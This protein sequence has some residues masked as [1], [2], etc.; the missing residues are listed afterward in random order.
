MKREQFTIQTVSVI[1][2][3]KLGTPLVAC[4]ASKGFSVIGVDANPEVVRLM[5][6]GV[7][8]V[9]EPGLDELLR[10]GHN[11][12]LATLDCRHAVLNSDLSFIVVPTPSEPSGG[13]STQHVLSVAEMIGEALRE[14][15]GYH[16]IALVSTVLPGTTEVDIKAVL[17]G[18]SGKKCGLDFGLCYSPEFI[19]LGRVIRDM[20][21]PDFILIGESDP[22]SGETLASFYRAFCDNDPAIS[23][24]NIL[25]AELTKIS[26]NSYITMKISFANNLAEICERLPGTDVDVVTSAMGQDTRIGRKYLKGALGYGGPCFPRDNAAFAYMARQVGAQPTMAE[27]TDSVNSR[28]IQRLLEIVTSHLDRSRTRVGILGLAYKP[29]TAVIEGSQSVELAQMLA[30]QGVPTVVYD[31]VAMD[32]ARKVLGQRALYARSMEECIQE[33]DVILLATPWAE[34]CEIR[35]EFFVSNS[36]RRVLIDC[37][38]LLCPADF[39]DVVEYVTIGMEMARPQRSPAYVKGGNDDQPPSLA[40]HV[41]GAHRQASGRKG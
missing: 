22:H 32:H 1:G 21:N 41:V 37:W 30:N 36:H 5:E 26:L 34:F 25:N 7:A 10:S 24:M 39:R 35:P 27:A 13:F 14:K 29:D 15:P 33:A 38:R 23:R 20:L 19:A 3:G 4:C 12:I 8:S 16:L 6:A 40:G 2:L 28:Q 17:E 9:P 31:P 18:S 11:R